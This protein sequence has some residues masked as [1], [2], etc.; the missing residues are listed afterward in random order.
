M[1]V[2]CGIIVYLLTLLGL[3]GPC[4]FSL[5]NMTAPLLYGDSAGEVGL[6]EKRQWV[7]DGLARASCLDNHGGWRPACVTQVRP[8]K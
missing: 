5:T 7:G 3:Q 4:S 1:V 6:G 2:L 8:K